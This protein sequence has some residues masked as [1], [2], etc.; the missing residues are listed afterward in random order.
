MNIYMLY[1][2]WFHGDLNREDSENL[3]TF[4]GKVGSFLI[5]NSKKHSK[6]LCLSLRYFESYSAPFVV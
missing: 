3:L 2:S 6:H 4:C 1:S 5:R